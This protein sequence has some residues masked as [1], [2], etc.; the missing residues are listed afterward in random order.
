[1]VIA[2]LKPGTVNN[3]RKAL[4]MFLAWC[5]FFGLEI[6]DYW[7]MLDDYL[8]E[9]K[10][11]PVWP[12]IRGKGVSKKEFETLIC[13]IVK[14][15]PQLR[16]GLPEVR[17]ALKAWKVV[18]A[19]SHTV[20]M[21]RP[22]ALLIALRLGRMGWPRTGALLVLQYFF[23]L[24]PSELL[25]LLGRN[26]VAA[27]VSTRKGVVAVVVGELRGTKR[28][29]VVRCLDPL[30]RLIVDYFFETTPADDPISG[31][32][33]YSTYYNQLKKACLAE[34]FE[35]IGFA[36]HSPRAG[37]ASDLGADGE[38]FV[39]IREHLRH[40]QDQSLRIYLDVILALNAQL[41]HQLHKRLSDAAVA[42]RDFT[43]LFPWW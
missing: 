13:A 39:A 38:D 36:P 40:R 8:L 28:A 19:V 32:L 24:R 1:M 37:R 12:K 31:G 16:T 26:L 29:Q 7:W 27:A 25:G 2:A 5:F 33:S 6:T 10:N 43:K 20:P 9:C 23:A 17:Q 34:G 30:C 35:D 22:W 42:K 14:C 11:C 4:I 3:Y 15:L 18:V 41:M 21:Y